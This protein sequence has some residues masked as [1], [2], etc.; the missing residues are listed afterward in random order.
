M[1]YSLRM[2]PP[3][4]TNTLGL[5][6]GHIVPPSSVNYSKEQEHICH[7]AAI[8]D[9]LQHRPRPFTQC[10]THLGW[11]TTMSAFEIHVSCKVQDHPNDSNCAIHNPASGIRINNQQTPDIQ[12]H[13]RKF[14]SKDLWYLPLPP[15]SWYRE[16]SFSYLWLNPTTDIHVVVWH[17]L[18]SAR[19]TAVL[20][21]DNVGL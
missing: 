20:L 21:A 3:R 8:E 12:N 5:P 17:K 11:N 10:G 7:A 19:P 18:T 9:Y 14:S 6:N 4:G 16:I 1:V 15:S 13:S 2:I